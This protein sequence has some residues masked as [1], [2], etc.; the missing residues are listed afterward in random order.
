MQEE[1]SAK[2]NIE[3]KVRQLLTL[4]PHLL[5]FFIS[6]SGSDDKFN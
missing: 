2:Q 5:F 6:S 4:P 1:T 3:E